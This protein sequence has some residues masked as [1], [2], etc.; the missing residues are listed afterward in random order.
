[1][2]KAHALILALWL[3]AAALTGCGR[4]T[5]YVTYVVVT[6]DPELTSLDNTGLGGGGIQ[7]QAE[8]PSA[9]TPAPTPTPDMTP[10]VALQVGDR[11]RVDGYY[12]NAIF[13]YQSILDRS[14]A[15]PEIQASAA[16]GLSQ[17]ALR[18]GLF[19]NA[20]DALTRLIVGFPGD[21]RTAQAFFLRG[22]AYSGLGQWASAISDYETYLQVRA[23]WIDSYVHERLG[24]AHLA[25]AQTDQAL[26]SYAQA[27]ASTRGQPSQDAAL[28]EKVARVY[29]TAGQTAEAVAQYDAILSFARVP[30][31]RAQVEYQAAQALLTAGDVSNAI[32]R[33]QRIVTEY[34]DTPSAYQALQTLQANGLT[35][36]SYA[37]GRILYFAGEYQAAIE[38]LT[39][40]GTQAALQSIP[41]EYHL[42]LGRAY[43]EVGNSE[44]AQIAF[45]TII[46]QYLTDPL[47]G[48]AL[49][50]QGRTL[51]LAGDVDAAIARYLEIAANYAALTDTAAQ[52]LWRAGY[53][54]ATNERP[55][56]ARAIFEELARLYPTTDEARSG[57]NIA[58]S[59]ALN[60]GDL[61]GAEA[62]FARLAE[63]T[64]GTDQSEASLQLG[65]LA[66]QRGDQE[67]GLAALNQA[68]ASSPDSYY[69]ARARDI[70]E[71]RPPFQPPAALDFQFDE[72]AEV[73]EAE[74]WLRAT[75]GIT[76]D[77]PLWPLSPTLESDPRMMR[78]RE[79]WELAAVDA[80]EVE[81]D[82][83]IDEAS[84]DALASYQLAILLRSIGA[85]RLSIVAGANVIIA[86]GQSTLDVPP[87]IARLRYPAYYRDVVV[88]V[89]GQ[90]AI[91]P[92]LM[93]SLIRHESL[94]DTNAEGAAGE[95]GLTQV[96][97]STGE[98]IAEQLN[99]P[100]YQ[101][102]D[103]FRAYAGIEFGA[104]YLDE[105]L[106]RFDGNVYAA[107]AGYNAG[108]GRSADWLAL[109][110]GDPDLF[111]SV[112]TIDSVQLYI[113]SIYANYTMYRALYGA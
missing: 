42:L 13:T 38:A 82:S 76:Q 7:Q 105:N 41:A 70:L 29:L 96:I 72:A 78:G 112:I 67:A 113:R 59:A 25:L 36:D 34:E 57:L 91:D 9:P 87:Y 24:D 107:L 17:A 85:F 52:A 48:E 4:E 86:S 104:F 88:R 79:L 5:V 92:L 53:L 20:V 46:E 108:P 95:N 101:H 10:E 100:D 35:V 89:T 54:H 98:Y 40:Y 109:S 37:Q 2:K 28:R 83:L 93:F 80:A 21:F 6:G 68:L 44:A 55:S 49:L 16:Y 106:T 73:T 8:T 110:G 12:E 19:A 65:R 69:G 32:I 61:A 71:N 60:A 23:G 64:T 56:E 15:P 50:E 97:P 62:L 11:Y 94:F 81:F 14:D 58:A 18:E 39:L 26:A 3:A 99:W 30:A 66:L 22:D 75:F 33:L 51:F 111:M 74:A 45:Q 77:G 1:M 103:L 63:I 43:R 90:R 47:F 31:Y 27:T 84:G 102:A